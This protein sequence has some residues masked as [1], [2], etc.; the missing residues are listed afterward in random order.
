[1][2]G[3]PASRSTV[4]SMEEAKPILFLDVDGVLNGAT[5]TYREYLL[6][7]AREELPRNDFV[8]RPQ[9]DVVSFRV[10]FDNSL[11]QL[12]GELGEYYELVWATTWEELAN[13]YLSPL[14]GLDQLGTVPLSL[15]PA[16]DHELFCHRVAQWKWRALVR[17]ADGRAFAFVDDKAWELADEYGSGRGLWPVVVVPDYLLSRAEVD[18]LVAEAKTTALDRLDRRVFS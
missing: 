7:V 4:L 17:Y 1:M 2:S 13:K 16:S 5:A 14:L 12:L 6:D 3:V 9:A 18:I 8:N 11:G 10:R 15:E